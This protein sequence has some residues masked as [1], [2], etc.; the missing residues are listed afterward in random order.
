MNGTFHS[1][2]CG[3]LLVNVP[4]HRLKVRAGQEAQWDLASSVYARVSM[5]V[6]K[7]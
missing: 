2:C 7:G 4:Q 5:H 6:R 1:V 3:S